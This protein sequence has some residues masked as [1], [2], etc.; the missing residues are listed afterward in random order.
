MSQDPDNPSS[1]GNHTCD[2][3]GSNHKRRFEDSDPDSSLPSKRPRDSGSQGGASPKSIWEDTASNNER[4]QSNQSAS[5]SEGRGV[6]EPRVNPID[7]IFQFHKVALMASADS[8]FRLFAS[9][10]LKYGD[11]WSHFSNLSMSLGDQAFPLD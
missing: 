9:N 5:T 1:Y 11:T 6:E 2:V 8:G 7:H 4:V 10:R 3:R